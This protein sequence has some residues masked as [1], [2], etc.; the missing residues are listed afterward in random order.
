MNKTFD[1]AAVSCIYQV[2]LNTVDLA[3]SDISN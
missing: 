1:F 2:V 3:D